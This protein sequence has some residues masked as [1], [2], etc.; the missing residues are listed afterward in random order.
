MDTRWR[1]MQELFEAAA[2][3]PT[4]ERQRFIVE[5]TA[6]DVAMRQQLEA[7]LSAEAAPNTRF[8]R[9]VGSVAAAVATGSP[10]QKSVGAYEVIGE[11]GHG[12]MGAVYLAQRADKQF[13]KKVAIK[14]A[15]FAAESSM[16]LQRFQHE[17][18]IL[19]TL[20]HS[21][22]ARLLDGG[23]TEDGMPYIV[24]EYVEGLSV[25]EYA[26]K[27]KLDLRSRIE[28]FLKI[29]AAVQHAHQALVIHR[30]LKPSNILVTDAGEP[31]LL[32]FGIAKLMEPGV[33]GFGQNT[34]TGM[35]MMT[36][37]YAS[38]EQVRGQ[39]VTTATDVYSLGAV[40]F[41]LLT[42]A[43]PHTLT[44]YTATE[45]D[46]VICE[47][48]IERPSRAA[49]RMGG[50][51][52]AF[53]ADLDII[54]L[55]AMH[56]EPQ[57]RY[58]SVAH[59]AD[60]LRRYIDGLPV[61]ARGDSPAY[62]AAR[63]LQRH[64]LGALAAAVL[65]LTL[66]GG[67]AATT[68]QARQAK[69]EARRADMRFKQV[70]HLANK[71]LFDFEEQIRRLNGS[72]PAREM[73]VKTA[74]EY[75][76]SLAAESSADPELR[77][78]LASAYVKLGDI[79]GNPRGAN[80]G[81]G[82]DAKVSYARAIELGRSVLD[83]GVR[84]GRVLDAVIRGE[85][86][87]GL[88]EGRTGS[89]VGLQS[90]LK[91][92]NE[93]AALAEELV[94]RDNRNLTGLRLQSA[95][96]RELGEYHSDTGNPA[97]ADERFRQALPVYEE[98]ARRDTSM[99]AQRGL[100]LIQQRIAGATAVNGDLQRARTLL[101]G[102]L[103]G[104]TRLAAS[105]QAGPSEQRSLMGAHLLLGALLGDPEVPN[106]G[107]PAEAQRISNAA[108]QIARRQAEADPANRAA[109][110]DLGI[111][112]AQLGRVLLA[113]NQAAAIAH[114]RRAVELSHELHK[115]SPDDRVYRRDFIGYRADLARVQSPAALRDLLKEM[116]SIQR[117]S[118]SIRLLR[119]ALQ[120]DLAVAMVRGE[121][122]R[123]H[124]LEALQTA[125]PHFRKSLAGIDS[126]YA[127]SRFY[128]AA[129]KVVDASYR[130]KARQLWADWLKK[131]PG[132]EYAKRM[133]QF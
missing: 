14:M 40:L 97:L 28:M 98:V 4:S 52:R 132:S 124:M 77:F 34:S 81:K 62:R 36:P 53:S 130:E 29:A 33:T 42:G 80:L 31:K 73:V 30:D 88:L 63:F 67:I 106:L 64:K 1:R 86:M 48:P 57:R 43:K 129:A 114:L 60:D 104:W 59:L 18:Q 119:A 74:R 19:A 35:R 109:K 131:D 125:E 37:D 112:E 38:P 110:A 51:T 17:R 3:L 79:Q 76:D 127:L 105:A 118:T 5:Q 22:I 8:D 94:K 93:S 84:E 89:E 91:R 61:L 39:Q 44:E 50:A 99:P 111:A 72:T 16:L 15:R 32:D 24:M 82:D 78:E 126:V 55:K 41:E 23:E 9:A 66:L 120:R 116:D 56:R 117:P 90:Y 102:N 107:Q 45:I 68:W 96:L 123:R 113:T 54:I 121:E 85:R 21:N 71:F 47:T 49:A 7:L 20:E 83:A 122:A 6:D 13:E 92:L 108:V 95:I 27:R 46:R 11:L 87:L 25:C 69:N 128:Q 2:E 100:L 101:E 115:A 75:L 103:D 10:H 133:M 65:L 26:E 70:R 12:G 58:E